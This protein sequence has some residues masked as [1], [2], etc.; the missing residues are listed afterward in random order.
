ME[1]TPNNFGRGKTIVETLFHLIPM[2]SWRALVRFVVSLREPLSRELSAFNHQ[3]ALGVN[4]VKRS[5]CNVSSSSTFEA[6]ATC[7]VANKGRSCEGSNV[8]TCNTHANSFAPFFEISH[9]ARHLRIWSSVF[10][11]SHILVFEMGAMLASPADYQNRLARFARLPLT[12]TTK[13]MWPSTN[14]NPFEGKQRV[15][16]CAT[17]ALLKRLVFDKRNEDLYALMRRNALD[18]A[19]PP[20]EPDFPAFRPFVC[21]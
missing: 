17:V 12:S 11:R 15:V 7:L 6:F 10:G 8:G 21:V 13:A 16:S 3:R 1:A 4:W 20:E 19:A 5:P 14:S 18:R 2:P 9:Y